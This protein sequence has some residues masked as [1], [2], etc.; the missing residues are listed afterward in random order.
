M[1]RT[2]ALTYARD[3]DDYLIVAYFL[4]CQLNGCSSS[5]QASCC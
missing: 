2:T 4:I 5:R 1:P 3:G